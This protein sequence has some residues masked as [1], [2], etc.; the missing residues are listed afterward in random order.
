[1]AHIKISK[2]LNI[3]IKGK[4]QGKIQT[5]LGSEATPHLKPVRIALNLDPFEDIGFRFLA[6]V[7][8]IVK[9]GQPLVEDKSTPGRVW[10][11]PA[12][13]VISEVRRGLKRRI[14][15]IIIDLAEDEGHHDH[16]TLDVE[17][18]TRDELID[19]LNKGGMFTRMRNRPFNVLANPAKQPRSIF[20]KAIESAPLAPPAEMQVEGN[21]EDFQIG[22]NA[23]AK[24]PEGDVHLVYRNDSTL[25]AFTEAKNVKRHTAE[26]P[27]PIGTFS[28]HI[29]HLDPIKSADDTIWTLNA[30]DV[31]CIGH[32]LRTGRYFTDRV[33]SI[34]GPGV[35]PE[36]TGYFKVREGFP[37]ESLISDR[38]QK[39]FIRLIS[40]NPLT[41]QK[42]EH[43]DYL[44]FYH[45]TF[46][47]IPESTDR[48]FLHF[49]RLGINKYSFSGAYLSGHLNNENREY[50]F[51]TSLH[52]EH[53]AFIDPTLYDKVN[54]LPIST[55]H[56]VKAVMAED[57]DL[58]EELGLLEVDS[59]DFALPTFVC[60]SKMEMT[61]IM[62]QGIKTYSKEFLK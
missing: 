31:V 58:A 19:K 33:I 34:A 40:G 29:Q 25:K 9:I 17:V 5:R 46:C 21:E 52:G 24:L 48:E 20:V 42:V 26:G 13:G 27:H 45:Y 22:L 6:K 54:P 18:A 47:A 23:I 56:L 50:D 44:G 49:F 15:D 14:L 57:Y 43:D 60:P 55:I 10:V 41:G 28:V 37:V 32:L 3:P 11:S 12:G 30:Q 8:D 39:G 36:R 35:I 16:G 59:E 4:P 53:R 62:K 61:E 1:M 2:G 7:G 51:N 38:I